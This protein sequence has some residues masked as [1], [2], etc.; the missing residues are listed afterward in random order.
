MQ[1]TLVFAGTSFVGRVLCG[2]LQRRGIKVTATSRTPV[3]G[4]HVCDVTD[5][6][7]VASLIAREQPS[8]VIQ[9]A[10]ATRGEDAWHCY[11]LHTQG[12]LNVLAAVGRHAPHATTLLLGSASEYGPVAPRDLPIRE[13]QCPAPTTFVGASKWAQTQL[14]V[15]AALEWN[16]RVLVIRPF[17]IIGPGLP[18]HYFLGAL[19][20]RLARQSPSERT[21][22]VHNADC[23]RDF[24]DVRDV[25][26][27][28]LLLLEQRRL[29]P[30][31][32]EVYNVASGEE[33]SL[34]QAALWL[35]HLAG[36]YE[37]CPVGNITSRTGIHRSCG[38]AARLR[39]TVG[40][41]I[42]YP[43]RQSVQDLWEATHAF[44]EPMVSTR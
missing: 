22:P 42:R 10:G 9:C 40:W 33:T 19:A 31:T 32:T 43:W 5:R 18:D 26:E 7:G 12:A 39:Q 41:Q 11:A 4:Y 24:I 25:V 14:A 34:L 2:A 35:G 16:L 29:T 13:S 1:T 17:N 37:P 8:W 44:A 20:S 38:D 6:E 3:P 27:A 23:T 36:G 21:F 30:G 28:I 15:A